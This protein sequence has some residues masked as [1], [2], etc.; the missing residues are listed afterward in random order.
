MAIWYWLEVE[1]QIPPIY[2]IAALR[3]EEKSLEVENKYANLNW[4]IKF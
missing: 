2:K 4:L 3:L 1:F